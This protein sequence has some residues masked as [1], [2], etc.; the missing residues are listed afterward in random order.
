MKSRCTV[1][2]AAARDS[3]LRDHRNGGG[4]RL[5]YRHLP[6]SLCRCSRAP[7]S[8]IFSNVLVWHVCHDDVTRKSWSFQLL[9]PVE[10]LK[11]KK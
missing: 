5:H 7:T 2:I 6:V 11:P 10:Y 1:Q 4:L 9:L 3:T 8:Y